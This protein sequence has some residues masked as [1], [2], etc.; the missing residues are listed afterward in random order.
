MNAAPFID[1]LF[2]LVIK[3]MYIQSQ[4]YSGSNKVYIV[5]C[6]LAIFIITHFYMLEKEQ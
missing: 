3:G 6:V 2:G 5:I 4:P 1:P